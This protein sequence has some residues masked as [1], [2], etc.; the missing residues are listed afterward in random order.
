MQLSLQVEM[1]IIAQQVSQINDIDFNFS[2]SSNG[3]SC[4]V[5]AH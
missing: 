5:S 3:F 1:N 2:I 4:G